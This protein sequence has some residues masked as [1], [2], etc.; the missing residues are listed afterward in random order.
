MNSID[1][2]KKHN[3]VSII[4]QLAAFLSCLSYQICGFAA[5]TFLTGRRET[6]IALYGEPLS[7]QLFWELYPNG[8]YE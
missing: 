4:L 7:V 6:I 3:I 2:I 8:K 5:Y 1:F